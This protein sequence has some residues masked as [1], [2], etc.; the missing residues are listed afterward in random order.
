[1]EE[2]F[3]KNSKSWCLC[4]HAPSIRKLVDKIHC[5]CGEERRIYEW[6][7]EDDSCVNVVLSN[8][9]RDVLFHPVYSSGTA[10]VKGRVAFKQNLHHYWEVK[11]LTNLYGTDIMIGVGTSKLVLSNWKLRFSSMLG[12]DTESWGYSYKGKIQ[13]NRLM[14]RYGSYFTIGSLVGVHLDMWTGTLQYYLNRRPLGIAFRSLKNYDLYPM[15]SSTAAQSAMRITCCLS[16]EPTLQAECLKVITK[17]PKLLEQLRNMPGI[18]RML[19]AKYFWLIPP[20][21]I[22]KKKI[23]LELEDEC[24][25]SL[26]TLNKNF[27]DCKRFRSSLLQPRADPDHISYRRYLRR[28]T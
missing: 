6:N 4:P 8:E 15:V 12:Y 24:V 10:A 23:S 22:E 2:R 18:M 17:N 28:S 9:N 19:S 20:P 27:K 13:H 1:M 7:W 11:I 25:L 5:T 3:R 16:Q 14:C 21:P 26:D